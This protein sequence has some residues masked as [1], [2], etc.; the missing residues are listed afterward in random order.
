MSTSELYSDESSS[1]VESERELRSDDYELEVE[2]FEVGS[3]SASNEASGKSWED[4][5]VA[6]AAFPYSDEPIADIEW[7]EEYE[8]KGERKTSC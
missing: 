4:N 8:R 6:A 5:T 3:A 1:S 2:E 7:I